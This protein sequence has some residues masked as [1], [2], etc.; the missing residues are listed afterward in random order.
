MSLSQQH[1]LDAVPTPPRWA[2]LPNSGLPDVP[3]QPA[4]P[5]AST[6]HGRLCLANSQLGVLSQ[7]HSQVLSLALCRGQGRN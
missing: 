6:Q 2:S 3:C 5:H 4:D 7:P 1:L